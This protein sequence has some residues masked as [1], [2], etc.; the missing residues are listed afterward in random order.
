MFDIN[1]EK[2]KFLGALIFLTKLPLPLIK[3]DESEINISRAF[4]AFPIIGFVF[5]L[6]SGGIIL[7]FYYAK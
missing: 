2:H 3:I 1:L 4:W 5:G 7:F 6:I